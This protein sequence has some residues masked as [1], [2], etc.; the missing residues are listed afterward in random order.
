MDKN[1]GCWRAWLVTSSLIAFIV[2]ACIAGFAVLLKYE[3]VLQ[4]QEQHIHELRDTVEG[5]M[6]KPM[7]ESEAHTLGRSAYVQ[8]LYCKQIWRK[9][10]LGA[11]VSPA[12]PEVRTQSKHVTPAAPPA[13]R[14]CVRSCELQQQQPKISNNRWAYVMMSYNQPGNAEHLCGVVAVAGAL[15]RLKSLYPLVVLT[16]TSNFPDGTSLTESLRRLNVILLPVYEVDMPV[17]H[18]KRLMYQHWKIAYWKLQIWNLVQF[19]KL[20]WLDSDTILFR[21]IDWIFQRPWMWAQRDDW[22]CQL[23]MT[24]VCSGIMLLYPN[25]SDFQGMIQHAEVMDDLTDGDQQ[26]I[27]SYFAVKRK[28]AISLLSDLEAAFG[29]CIGKPPAPYINADGSA[30]WGIW[31]MPSFVH[32]SGGWGNTND[33]LY[34][35]VCFMPNITMQ[36]YTVGGATLNMC[37]FHP[38]GPYWRRLFC[39][40]IAVM[41]VRLEELEAFCDDECWYRGKPQGS[42][43]SGSTQHPF[44][45]TINGTLSYMDYYKRTVGYPPAEVPQWHMR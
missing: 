38:L 36:L 5:L 7:S 14:G 24:K 21:N 13:V 17:K 19:E 16:N 34:S 37:Q 43:I 33:N 18:Q 41:G 31:N 4:R 12:A 10:Q 39:D 40:A 28:K 20:I 42:A 35:N 3:R 27:S 26:L 45:G 29:Q 25:A 15:R 22:F 23:N 9:E 2:G 32:K 44:C 8:E 11:G 1:A 30:V 6:T